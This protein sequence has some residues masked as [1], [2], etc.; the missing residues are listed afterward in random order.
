MFGT[1]FW[2]QSFQTFP[3]YT[4]SYYFHVGQYCND[5]INEINTWFRPIVFAKWHWSYSLSLSQFYFPKQLNVVYNPI[6]T[7]DGLG[8]KNSLAYKHGGSQLL[9]CC[10][11][12]KNRFPVERFW[13]FLITSRWPQNMHKYREILLKNNACIGEFH[14]TEKHRWI[15]KNYDDQIFAGVCIIFAVLPQTSV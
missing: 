3:W 8:Q 5:V 6:S 2:Y 4:Y 1:A 9:P 7:H 10:P 13:Y 11:W 12:L 14:R 15:G